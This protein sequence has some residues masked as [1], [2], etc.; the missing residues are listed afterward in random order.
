MITEE[1]LSTRE[2]IIL[3]SAQIIVEEGLRKFTAKNIGD[4]VGITD[5]AIYKHFP[6]LD[7]IV[8]E[9]INR[10][11]S[12]CSQSVERALELGL[13]TEETLKQVM[14][15][16]IAV[17]EETRGA[18]PILCF[19]FSRSGNKKFF[20]ILH[21]FVENY[22]NKLSQILLK[23]QQEGLIRQDIEP[24][25]TAMLFVGLIQAKV[26]AYVMERREGPIIRNSDQLISELFYGII[27]R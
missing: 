19:E 26:F 10:Y 25:E 11:I 14:R 21:S 17:L 7:S 13:S 23:G 2:K 9:I 24:T 27:N 8:I 4:R 16:H 3:A 18:V 6:S 22:K 5:A 20:D 12:R 1:E 15:E